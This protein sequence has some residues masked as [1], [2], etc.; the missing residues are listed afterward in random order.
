[1]KKRKERLEKKKEQRHGA[2]EQWMDML[3]QHING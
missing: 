3:L 2:E 1:M